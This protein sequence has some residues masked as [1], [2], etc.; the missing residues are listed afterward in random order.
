MGD[1][2]VYRIDLARGVSYVGSS[3]ASY[4][5]RNMRILNWNYRHYSGIKFCQAQVSASKSNF[6]PGVVNFKIAERGD[7]RGRNGIFVY[8]YGVESFSRCVNAVGREARS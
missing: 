2:R 8:T 7:G 1:G 3:F 5:D 4:V 6:H